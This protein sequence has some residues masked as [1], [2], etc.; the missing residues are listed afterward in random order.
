MRYVV[1][2]R[3]RRGGWLRGAETHDRLYAAVCE[4]KRVRDAGGVPRIVQLAGEGMGHPAKMWRVVARR[5]CRS[6]TGTGRPA[7]PWRAT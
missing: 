1:E 3:T 7:A 6:I 5:D 4:A 2:V